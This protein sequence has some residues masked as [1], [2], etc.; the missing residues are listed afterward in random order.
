[1]TKRLDTTVDFLLHHYSSQFG[2]W[3]FVELQHFH[4]Y[5]QPSLIYNHS[6]YHLD[7]KNMFVYLRIYPIG[8]FSQSYAPMVI[9]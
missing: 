1:M 7:E 2:H 4:V 3:V 8:L 6:N 9:R 5:K